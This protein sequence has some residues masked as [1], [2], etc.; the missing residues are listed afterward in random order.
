MNRNNDII[1]LGVEGSG[2]LSY[3]APP[4]TG[5]LHYHIPCS[6]HD[7]DCIKDSSHYLFGVNRKHHRL[8]LTD[9]YPEWEQ[10]YIIIQN[11]NEERDRLM[12][13]ELRSLVEAK[14]KGG[15]VELLSRMTPKEAQRAAIY[16]LN[17]TE[18]ECV[19][20]LLDEAQVCLWRLLKDECKYIPS[21]V[22]IKLD[23]AAG[24]FTW[25][26][27][28]IQLPDTIRPAPLVRT[29]NVALKDVPATLQEMLDV[30][31]STILSGNFAQYDVSG[32]VEMV[33]V[34]GS[35]TW[36]EAL[37]WDVAAQANIEPGFTITFT[38]VD[39]DEQGGEEE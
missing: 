24:E 34:P 29:R 23:Q 22:T 8:H 35:R 13:G 32:S 25:L 38:N 12:W 3:Y 10:D 17:K 15:L 7:P 16:I 5:T 2:S 9:F 14:I 36:V 30:L 27:I 6:K 31:E 20:D 26:R 4:V 28:N 39:S 37:E 18:S 1:H 21:F 11:P 33:T 19:Q